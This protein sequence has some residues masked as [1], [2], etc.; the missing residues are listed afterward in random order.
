VE[1]R[2]DDDA[3][4]SSSHSTHST[5]TP[6]AVDDAVPADSESNLATRGVGNTPNSHGDEQQQQI[7]RDTRNTSVD[8]DQG[9]A[10]LLSYIQYAMT[11]DL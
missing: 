8:V 9:I 2:S 3:R 4:V 6:A 1:R 10:F 5:V 11:R 7:R